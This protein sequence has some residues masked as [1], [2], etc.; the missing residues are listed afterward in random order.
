MESLTVAD[1]NSGSPIYSLPFPRPKYQ[2]WDKV[3]VEQVKAGTEGDNP[4]WELHTAIICGM[5]WNPRC[6]EWEYS[7]Y[8]PTAPCPWLQDGY[9]DPFTLTDSSLYPMDFKLAS[10]TR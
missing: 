2:V 9:F 10:Q 3:Q 6:K 1:R 5:Q 7:L 8:F 4:V